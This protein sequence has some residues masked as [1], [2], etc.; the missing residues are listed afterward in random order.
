M[1]M[2]GCG[3]TSTFEAELLATLIDAILL[4]YWIEMKSILGV[5]RALENS[6]KYFL[7]QLILLRIMF[8]LMYMYP[9]LSLKTEFLANSTGKSLVDGVIIDGVTSVDGSLI[10][11]EP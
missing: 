3:A 8:I 6:P 4:G 7:P 10:T 5:L 1:A 9:W 11:G 2:V